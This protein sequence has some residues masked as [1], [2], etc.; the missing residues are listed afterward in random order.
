LVALFV[1][2][3]LGSASRTSTW[4]KGVVRERWAWHVHAI[5]DVTLASFVVGASAIASI[6][7]HAA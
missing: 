2:R 6:V 4:A 3:A 7:W 5:S 1:P